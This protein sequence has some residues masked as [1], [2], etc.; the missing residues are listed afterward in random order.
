MFLVTYPVSAF[1]GQMINHPNQA[2]IRNFDTTNREE[3]LKVFLMLLAQ[4]G[5]TLEYYNMS[6]RSSSSHF[7]N[8]DNLIDDINDEEID[9]ENNLCV[10]LN[11][12]EQDVINILDG[13]KRDFV[14]IDGDTNKPLRCKDGEVFVYGSFEGAMDD[15]GENDKLH[16]LLSIVDQNEKDKCIVHDFSMEYENVTEVGTF[17]S[18]AKSS[19]Q[20]FDDASTYFEPKVEAPTNPYE[21]MQVTL[22]IQTDYGFTADFLRE[23]ANQIEEQGEELTTY[24][25][26]RGCADIEWP[27][28]LIPAS[29]VQ[30]SL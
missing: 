19:Q 22:K 17:K 15:F 25:T 13:Y 14:I 5:D 11:I 12:E 29:N 2:P 18:S 24:E 3:S 7:E 16:C 10:L 28:I 6:S 8:I 30:F 21:D 9:F 4:F 1:E 26:F 23:L 20:W 27:P